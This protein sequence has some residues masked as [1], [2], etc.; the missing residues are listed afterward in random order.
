ML[1]MRGN[2]RVEKYTMLFICILLLGAGLRLLG[3]DKGIWLD[4]YSSIENISYK[5][6]TREDVAGYP[7]LGKLVNLPHPS[8][9][10][11]FVLESV[12]MFTSL[13]LYDHPPLYFVLLKV[14]SFIS[15]EETSLRLFSVL[16]GMATLV[17]V[18][19]WMKQTSPAAALAAGLLCAVTPIMVR[20]SQE[21]RNY[22]VLLLATAASFY[23]ASR[24]AAEPSKWR[25]AIGLTIGL[26]AAVSSHLVGAMV[27][28]TIFLY[29]VLSM[30]DWRRI[31]FK[32]VVAVVIPAALFCFFNF[33]YLKMLDK[34]T[35][36]W[37]PI[38]TLDNIADKAV[39]LSGWNSFYWL[40]SVCQTGLIS[41]S[42]RLFLIRSVVVIG[43]VFFLLLGEWRKSGR[44]L[45]VTIFFWLQLLVYSWVAVPIFLERTALPGMIPFWGFVGSH[46]STIGNEKFRR[47][48]FCGLLLICLVFTGFWIFDQ[49]GKPFEPVREMAQVLNDIGGPDDIFIFYPEF[50]QGPV[51]YYLPELP[52]E[53]TVQVTI[54]MDIKTLELPDR[55]DDSSLF[56]VA[57]ETKVNRENK[58]FLQLLDYLQAEYGPPEIVFQNIWSIRHYEH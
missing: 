8:I 45:A 54:N 6:L 52:L 43:S 23:Y 5:E 18:V 46:I 25:H 26:A 42:T 57:R 13:R 56:L 10:E 41:Y 1:M 3:L 4:E 38:P 55:G 12:S 21:I 28:S 53:N 15:A 48:A 50:A 16:M 47:L 24:L 35:N 20:Y 31:F 9:V 17:Y 32:T 29:I 40:T 33:F 44:L 49:A 2:F 36:W 37:I 51:M 27:V 34:S 19:L 7:V 11:T 58:T 22:S 14:W 39:L 30:P